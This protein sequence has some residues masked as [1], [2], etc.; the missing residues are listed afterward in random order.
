[1]STQDKGKDCRASIKMPHPTK[2]KVAILASYHQ[3]PMYLVIEELADVE[4]RKLRL[5]TK[6]EYG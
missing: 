2:A 3:K 4:I 6:G 1:M 5:K